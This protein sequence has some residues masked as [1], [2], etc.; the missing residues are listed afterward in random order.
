MTAPAFRLTDA[1]RTDVG[2]VRKINE[3]SYIARPDIGLWGVA[4]G[5]GGH[6]NGEWASQTVVAALEKVAPEGDF[7]VDATKVADA[8]HAANSVIHE[9][10]QA[11][12]RQMGSTA[13]VLLIEQP[14]FAAMWAGDSRVYLLRA[15]KLVR[16]TRDHTQVQEMIDH[17]LL[18]E[19]EAKSHP[20]VHVISRA[21]GVE[22]SLEL[23]AIVDQAE[24]G[25]VFLLCSDGLYGMVNDDEI[26]GVLASAAPEGVCKTLVSLALERGAPD[27]VTVVTV[28][29]EEV[30]RVTFA[31]SEA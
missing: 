27:N 10:V 14:N 18:T 12:G 19:A 13:A 30:T 28:A 7:T 16:I 20:M 29:C 23:D 9:Q 4:D 17:G 31:T 8:I 15:G 5:M 2:T 11:K 26:A 6:D 25:D 21:V 22:S 24:P 1:A 3:D